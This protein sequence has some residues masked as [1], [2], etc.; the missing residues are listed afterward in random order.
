MA[1]LGN[2]SEMY[3]DEDDIERMS[4]KKITRKRT[5]KVKSKGL[6]SLIIKAKTKEKAILKYV[7]AKMKKDK[8]EVIRKKD[9]KIKLKG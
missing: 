8:V 4:S 1:I 9:I 6:K 3:H 7:Q 5:Y 2:R